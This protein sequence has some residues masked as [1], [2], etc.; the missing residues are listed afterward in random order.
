MATDILQIKD[1][2]ANKGGVYSSSVS[3]VLTA[4]LYRD[5]YEEELLNVKEIR[6]EL[7]SNIIEAVEEYARV[8]IETLLKLYD[9][10]QMVP[11]FDLSERTSEQ[12]FALQELLE[13][14]LDEILADDELVWSVLENYIPSVLIDKL[15]RE[16]IMEILASAELVAYRDAIITKKL[17]SLALYGFGDKWES[18]L[19]DVEK[20]MVSA[21]KKVF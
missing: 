20:D 14:R 15:G 2:S 13:E 10:D 4:F 19:A 12:I 16:Q 21:L 5:G 18:F 11:L 7:I 3:E 17:A 1:T 6:W 9:A 8:E